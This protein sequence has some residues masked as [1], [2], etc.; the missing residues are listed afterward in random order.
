MRRVCNACSGEPVE[1]PDNEVNAH[2]G[3]PGYS[4]DVDGLIAAIPRPQGIDADKFSPIAEELFAR[5]VQMADNAGATDEHRA[6]NY[7]AVRYDAIY[8]KTAESF[9][10]NLSLSAIEVRPAPIRA[11]RKIVDVIFTY[12]HRETGVQEKHAARVDVAEQF[13]FLV[14]KLSPYYDRHA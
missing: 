8:G 11:T 7:L 1:V 9:A 6:V 13:P 5:T 10:R 2:L 4:F 14:S 12:T 3:N